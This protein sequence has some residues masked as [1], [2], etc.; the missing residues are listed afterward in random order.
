MKFKC[1]E[2]TRILR[3]VIKDYFFFYCSS[4]GRP[5]HGFLI[6]RLKRNK[7]IHPP[8]PATKIQLVQSS[9]ILSALLQAISLVSP[10]PLRQLCPPQNTPVWGHPGYAETQQGAARSCDPQYQNRGQCF[11]QD[12]NSRQLDGMC[13]QDAAFLGHIQL[14]SSGGLVADRS[15]Q[16]LN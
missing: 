3:T 8:P 16:S 2:G 9:L 13:Q 4:A 7:D 14:N 11:F 15:V 1:W 5:S 10:N 6:I 12:T